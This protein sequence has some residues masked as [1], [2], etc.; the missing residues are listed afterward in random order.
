MK[1]IKII[2]VFLFS[3]TVMFINAQQGNSLSINENDVEKI[4]QE[5]AAVYAEKIGL[6]KLQLAILTNTMTKYG[7]KALEVHRKEL[8]IR[9][10]ADLI[11]EIK[12]ARKQELSQF[13]SEEQVEKLE[14]LEKKDSKK[15]KN[16]RP[17]FESR[18]KYKQLTRGRGF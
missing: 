1:H 8:P 6:D 9:Q 4:M 11:K 17:D 3:F 18:R 14:K 16:V 13:L 2:F 10:K 5:K 15:R 12:Q 7:I